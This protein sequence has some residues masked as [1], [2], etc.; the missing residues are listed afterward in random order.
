[1]RKG[2]F[3][4]LLGRASF[5]RLQ[6]PGA[7]FARLDK[8]K[9]VPRG[10]CFSLPAGRQPGLFYRA[11][12][13]LAIFTCAVLS[14]QPRPEPRKSAPPARPAPSKILKPAPKPQVHLP[15]HRPSPAPKAATPRPRTV[16]STAPAVRHLGPNPAVITGAKASSGTIDGTKVHRKP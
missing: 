10:A 15:A 1:M 4:A 13:I 8:L 6:S 9:H 7:S 12:L 5:A 3:M 14:A 11:V 16:R 2:I